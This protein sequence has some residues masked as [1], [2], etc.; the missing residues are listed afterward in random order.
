MQE[1]YHKWHSQYLNHN[2]EMLVFGSYGYPI[3]LFPTEKGKYY[4]CKN[5]SLITSIQHFIEEGKI[6]IYCPEVIDSESWYNF[7][8][9]PAERV[10]KHIIY[11]KVILNDVLE[12]AKYETEQKFVGVAG[13]SFGGYHAINLAFRHPDKISSVISMGGF[14]DIKQFIYGYYDDNCYFNNPPDYM[15]N[16]EDEWYLEKIRTMKIFIGTGEFD[17]TINENKKL[18]DI[19]TSKSIN[20]SFNI[21]NAGKHD[22][23][24]WKIMFVDYVSKILESNQ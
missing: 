24:T 13:C 1:S 23:E 8:I 10:K 15:P 11:E 21:Y 7:D 22:W 14:F 16:L 9:Q 12:F 6:K 2:L 18:S 3:I 19:L 5:F 4:D 17:F 20:H